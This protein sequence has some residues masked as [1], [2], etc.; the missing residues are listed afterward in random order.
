MEMARLQKNTFGKLLSLWRAYYMLCEMLNFIV[1]GMPRNQ[2]AAYVVQCLKCCHQVAIDGGNWSVGVHLIPTGDPLERP[3][4]GG[5]EAELE[6]VHSYTKS[7]NEL[8]AKSKNVDN[9]H[10]EVD[11]S[12]PKQKPHWVRKKEKEAEKK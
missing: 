10:E 12:A 6:A 1:T 3:L 11:E 7:V 9:H 4:F 2:I 8:K 5:D